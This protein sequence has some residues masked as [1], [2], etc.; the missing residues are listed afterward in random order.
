[1][2]GYDWPRLHAALNDFPAA[3]LLVSVLFDVAG[4]LLKR[5]TLKTVGFWTLLTGVAGTAAAVA[6][7]L[8]TEDVI[9]HSDQAHALMERH[10]TF[11]LTV[12]AVFAVLAVWRLV[13]RGTWRPRELPVALAVGAVGVGLMV[14]TAQ[15]GGA[16]VF[17]HAL[18][19][20]TARLGAVEAER[21]GEAHEHAPG[22][23]HDMEMADTTQADT[24]AARRDTATAV[25][26]DESKPHTHTD[27]TAHTRKNE[28]D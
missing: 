20:P 8:L 28:E 27:S 26:R 2:F 25:R 21:G 18:G 22:E 16:L 23:E 1:M 12:L 5:E 24:A 3:L 13:R 6:A 14:Y 7:G 10:E 4:A 15:L 17:D 9:D 19:I 11:G